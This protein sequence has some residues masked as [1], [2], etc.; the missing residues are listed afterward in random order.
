MST[1]NQKKLEAEVVQVK[2]VLEIVME[3][4]VLFCKN[5]AFLTDIC[6]SMLLNM[7]DRL[8]DQEYYEDESAD[9]VVEALVESAYCMI[10][11]VNELYF[12]QFLDDD[13]T[14]VDDG[15]IEAAMKILRKASEH[16]SD[17]S[18]RIKHL[19]EIVGYE[20]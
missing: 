6:Q 12:D 19:Y 1:I 10:A 18:D 13:S 2:R 15:Y 7:S 14:T 4:D 20:P 5:N 11:T 9:S 3:S 8:D 16:L 17:V